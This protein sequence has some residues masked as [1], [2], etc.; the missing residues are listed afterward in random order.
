MFVGSKISSIN[1]EEY[2][3]ECAEHGNRCKW[4]N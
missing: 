1:T 2:L 3:M 4:K